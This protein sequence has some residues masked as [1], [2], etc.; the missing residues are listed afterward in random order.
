MS[1]T[2]TY[3]GTG[4]GLS[5]SKA[6]VEMLGGKNWVESEEDKG[7]GFYFTIPIM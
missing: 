1:T 6:C 4:L 7:S 3:D 2:R 5:I